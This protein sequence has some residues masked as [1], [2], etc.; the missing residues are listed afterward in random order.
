[1]IKFLNLRFQYFALLNKYRK[2]LQ[3]QCKLVLEENQLL[4][5]QNDLHQ[6]R[7]RSFQTT[8]LTEGY[9]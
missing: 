5:E 2:Q 7:I 9:L 1:M 3:Q 4:L 8:H 6:G